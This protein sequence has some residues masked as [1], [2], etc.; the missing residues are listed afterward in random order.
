MARCKSD[1]KTPQRKTP[2]ATTLSARFNK[3]VMTTI[4]TG[5]VRRRAPA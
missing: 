5:K 3:N 2:L 1:E 4:S